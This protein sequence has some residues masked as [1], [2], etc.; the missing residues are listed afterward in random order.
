MRL[1]QIAYYCTTEAEADEIKVDLK[2]NK[3][4]WITDLVTGQSKVVNGTEVKNGINVAELSFCYALGIELE[5]IRY[6]AGPH[7]HPQPIGRKSISHIGIHLDDG[8]AFPL[9]PHSR[10]VQETHTISHT[11]AYLTDPK[12]PG[13]KRKYH[14]R[15]HELGPGSYVKYIRR[16]YPNG[17]AYA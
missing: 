5:I 16:I 12:S 4:A 3:A 17:N 14:Y 15:I 10:L 2:L 1:D 9:M 6:I 13:Y 11:S 7:W 8:E